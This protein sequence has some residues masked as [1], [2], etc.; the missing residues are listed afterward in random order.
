MRILELFPKEW[1]PVSRPEWRETVSQGFFGQSAFHRKWSGLPRDLIEVRS[2]V[3]P[4]AVIRS[5]T[6]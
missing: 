3:K 4:H 5:G 1:E 6:A 2:P